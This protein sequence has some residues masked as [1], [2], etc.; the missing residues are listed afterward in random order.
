MLKKPITF[1]DPISGDT[2]TQDY[3][4]N[5]TTAECMELQ[6]SEAEGWAE[7]MEQTLLNEDR[8]QLVMAVKD[9]ILRSYGVRIGGDFVKTP[10]KARAFSSSE[11]Y[12]ALFMELLTDSAASAAFLN[13][14]MPKDLAAEIS[15]NTPAKPSRLDAQVENAKQNYRSRDELL[16][17]MKAK[18]K[19]WP[20][21]L[22]YDEVVEMSQED[23]DEAMAA[24]CT[25]PSE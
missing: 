14:V 18:S 20:K 9:I 16:R 22:S 23:L 1:E 4:F 12:S 2:V 24:G 8:T 21:E 15:K 10:E 25:I 19:G 7:K 6:L 11:A 13:G 17:K 3:Y 5:L